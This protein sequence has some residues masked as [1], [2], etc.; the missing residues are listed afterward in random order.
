MKKVVSFYEVQYKELCD[1]LE[2]LEEAVRQQEEFGATGYEDYSEGEDDDDDDSIS[3][4]P[5]R[6]GTRRRG[7]VNRTVSRQRRAS[8]STSL[9]RMAS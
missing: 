6:A 9:S 5:S 8:L 1:E 2:E 4:S 3:R 7:S